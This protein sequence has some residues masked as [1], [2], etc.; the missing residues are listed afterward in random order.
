M[1]LKK[2]TCRGLVVS[3]LALSFQT[4]GAGMIGAEQATPGT[5]QT[6]RSMVLEVLARAETSSQLEALGVDPRQA[7]DRVAAMNDQEVTQLASDI[8]QAPAGA[9]GGTL[10][11][12]LV[13]AA[14]VWYFM[15]RR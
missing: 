6:D 9:D 2:M 3:M 8:R 7:R 10:L 15:F 13:I 5:A 4:A 12:V 14:A 11:A 1:N